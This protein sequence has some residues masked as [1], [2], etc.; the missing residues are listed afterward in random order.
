M[1]TCSISPTVT[2]STENGMESNRWT[3]SDYLR[4]GL[5]GF[6]PEGL[7]SIDVTYRCNLNCLHCYFN[8]QDYTSELSSDRWATELKR[9]ESRGAPL[10]ICGW[11][12]GEPLLRPEV[13]EAGKRF[14][15]SNI[16]FTNGTLQLPPWPDC[17][18]VVSVP[19]TRV[20]Y[21]ELTGAE[22][23]TYDLVKEH[24]NRLDLHVIV[25]FCITRRNV[26]SILNFLSE[27]Q[28]E[29]RIQGVFFEFYTPGK[30][31]GN[32]LWLDWAERDRVLDMLLELKKIY[33]DFIYNTTL[34]LK[35]MKSGSLR[36]TLSDCPFSYIGLSLDPMGRIKFPCALGPEADCKRCGC[37]L[38]VFSLL[39][40]RKGLLIQAFAEGIKRKIREMRQQ[41]GAM[42]KEVN[43]LHND[44]NSRLTR[45]A[46]FKKDDFF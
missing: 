5:T 39:L 15:K 18:F 19:G 41:E 11:L 23:T 1:V 8:R 44:L 13:I 28:N 6:P 46:V 43:E 40:W 34:M 9:M 45:P 10:Y 20:P 26:S 29:T 32:E 35:L 37:I 30:G 42:P 3:F 7:M 25:S 16:V 4:I 27:W 38:P 12:G 24:A 2:R 33:K 22:S 31:E 17:T 14:F 21:Q 36:K